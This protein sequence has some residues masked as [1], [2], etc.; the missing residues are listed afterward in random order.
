MTKQELRKLYK[1]KRND[2]HA[3]ERLRLDDLLLLQ[4]QQLDYSAVQTVLTYWPLSHHAEPNTLL[5]SGYLRHMIP[6]LVMAY[7]L[8]DIPSK[9]MTALAIHEDTVYHT[10]QW[11]ITEPKEGAVLQ[12]AEIDMVFVPL[13]ACDK[14]GYRVGYGQGFYDRYLANCRGDVVRIGFSYFDPI[15]KI[16]DTSEFDIPLTHCI[17]PQ[18]VYEF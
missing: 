14:H 3:T 17:T 2:I 10:S 7:P 4:F 12:P 11:G 15:E 18:H 9:Q 1:A 16:T 6:G 5:F 8:T 13:L